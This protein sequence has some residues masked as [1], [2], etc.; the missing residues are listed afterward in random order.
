MPASP[1][2]PPV[3]YVMID[4]PAGATITI[5]STLIINAI[6]VTIR[7]TGSGATLDGADARRLVHVSNGGKLVLENVHLKNGHVVDEAGGCGL[8]EGGG[9]ELHILGATVCFS[10]TPLSPS[11]LPSLSPFTRHPL[12]LHLV[13]S[14]SR[15]TL[16]LR[17]HS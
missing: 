2:P 9:S 10:M 5:A 14:P 15:D 11:P 7:S 4:I 12:T 8:V 13:S 16:A 17:P 6:F 3:A 1:P